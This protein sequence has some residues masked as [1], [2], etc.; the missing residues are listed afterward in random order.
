MNFYFILCRLEH[1]HAASFS[2]AGIIPRKFA[3][4]PIAILPQITIISLL[5]NDGFYIFVMAGFRYHLPSIYFLRL[6]AQLF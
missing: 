6:L 3:L 5:S 2:H 1:F 4:A